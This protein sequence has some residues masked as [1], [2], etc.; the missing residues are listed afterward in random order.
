MYSPSDLEF[1]N[2]LILP[3]RY[4]KSQKNLQRYFLPSSYSFG[5]K[6]LILNFTIDKLMNII[7]KR[8]TGINSLNFQ[9]RHWFPKWYSTLVIITILFPLF[10]GFR[11]S[12]L[13]RGDFLC[14]WNKR[15]RQKYWVGFLS[16][17]IIEF[18]RSQHFLFICIAAFSNG[19]FA[20]KHC[21]S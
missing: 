21:S 12:F 10:Y 15:N 11:N 14:G 17:H 8:T 6:S 3:E 18:S 13:L 2:I 16:D 5:L 9:R 7:I 20:S 1:R 4:E 19:T